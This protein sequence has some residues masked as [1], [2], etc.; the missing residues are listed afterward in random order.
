MEIL[1]KTELRL[2]LDEF[3]EKISDGAVFIYPTDTI[4]GIGCNALNKRSV[5]KVREL[6]IRES[7]PFS[8]W[9]PSTKWIKDNCVLD[10][11]DQ[12]SFEKLPGP[13]TLVLELKN[14]KSLADNVAPGIKTLG[15]R[16]PDHWFSKV[17]EKLDIPIVTTSA[18][19][20]GRPFMT[21]VENLDPEIKEGI[22]FMIY[23]GPKEGQP[24]KIINLVKGMVKER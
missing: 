4:Y 1:T 20:T 10:K 17:V 7:A 19:K 14:E 21:S 8:V 23:E 5:A 18:N 13:I 12:D 9:A 11:K 16:I 3:L 24:S 2:R 6:K 22:D 15:V